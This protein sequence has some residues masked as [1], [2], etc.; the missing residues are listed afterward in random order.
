MKNKKGWI[1]IIEAFIA[2]LLIIGVVLIAVD[3][4]YFTGEEI[5]ARVYRAQNALL[6]EI[7]L[8]ESLRNEVLSPSVQAPVSWD[9]FDSSGLPNVRE[10]IEAGIPEYLQCEAKLCELDKICELDDQII[11]ENVYAQAVSI[12]ANLTDYNPKQVKLFCWVR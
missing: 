3:Q 10:K 6:R 5:S 9:D 4:G 12:A 1:R 11:N 8:D 2:L 7:Q